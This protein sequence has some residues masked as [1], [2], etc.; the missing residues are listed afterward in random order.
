[1]FDKRQRAR[2]AVAA[3]AGT[4]FV[5]ETVLSLGHV[6]QD[7]F[8]RFGALWAKHLGEEYSFEYPLMPELT[9]HTQNVLQGDRFKTLCPQ[10][11]YPLPVTP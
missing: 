6:V 7:A 4:V 11:T 3:V 1:L 8:P 2:A 10:C 5:V 9:V